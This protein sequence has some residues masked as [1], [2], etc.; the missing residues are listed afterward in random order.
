[1][2]NAI[3]GV[4]GVSRFCILKSFCFVSLPL[5]GF[6]IK[7]DLRFGIEVSI[8]VH[9]AGGRAREILLVEDM[10]KLWKRLRIGSQSSPSF[11]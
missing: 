1:M 3:T 4:Q 8:N 5:S 2:S 9:A 6:L 10:T 7:K 11:L